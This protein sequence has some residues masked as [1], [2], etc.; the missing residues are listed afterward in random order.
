MLGAGSKKLLS[1]PGP[2]HIHPPHIPSLPSSKVCSQGLRG[3]RPMFTPPPLLPSSWYEADN[4]QGNNGQGLIQNWRKGTEGQSPP[5]PSPS[6][7]EQPT[8]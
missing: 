2:A 5:F 8:L 6:A 1:Q 4:L 7:H 3:G